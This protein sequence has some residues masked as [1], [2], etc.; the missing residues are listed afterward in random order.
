MELTR[1]IIKIQMVTQG[2]LPNYP[3]HLISDNEMCDAFI[4]YPSDENMTDDE[5]WEAFMSSDQVTWF[6]YYYDMPDIS[7]LP[8]TAPDT[9]PKK[10]GPG[11]EPIPYRDREPNQRDLLAAYRHLVE[12]IASIIQSFKNSPS[13]TRVLPQWIYSYMI[14]ST[15]NSKSSAY[16]RHDLLNYAG[17][18]NIEDELTPLTYW[19]CFVQSY[20]WVTKTATSDPAYRN[21]TI[22][23]EPHVMKSF[24]VDAANIKR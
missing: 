10:D 5:K 15:I 23:G 17:E 2:F 16:D 20:E 8:E 12:Q 3:Y 13:D 9:R 14:G 7:S 18:S 19:R 4:Q 21:P 6:K 22:F 1:D 11:E 24:W